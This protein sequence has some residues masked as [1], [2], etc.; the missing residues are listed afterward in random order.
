M[1]RLPNPGQDNGTWGHI[2][3]EYLS[4]VHNADGSLKD[5]IVAP[6]NLNNE[7]SDKI[8]AVAA[9]GSANLSISATVNSVTVVSDTGDDATI[10]PATNSLAG[11]MT[12]GDKTKLDG[13]ATGAQ[14]NAVTSVAGKT[15]AVTL[16]ATDV[17]AITRPSGLQ[18]GD[19]LQYDETTD[20]FI[21]LDPTTIPGSQI[22]DHVSATDPHAVAKYAI[23]P[24]GGRHIFTRSTDPG[25]EAIDG[26]IWLPS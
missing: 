9:G 23:M 21:R 12:A 1:S 14:V 6:S 5:G 8:N 22:S 19:L 13:I 17:G 24:D 15:G 2:L 26:D 20:S 25:S 16:N 10:A 4:V 11:V 7:L 3:N 18:D